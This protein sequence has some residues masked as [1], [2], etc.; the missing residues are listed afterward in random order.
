MRF[1]LSTLLLSVV[2]AA[3]CLGWYIDH[4]RSRG[5]NI[6]GAWISATDR[7]PMIM[8]DYSTLDVEQNGTFS[9]VQYSQDSWTTFSGTYCANEDGTFTFHVTKSVTKDSLI[10]D[11]PETTECDL[12]F[13]CRCAID[14]AG[15][16]MIEDC[17]KYIGFGL[18]PLVTWETLRP[19]TF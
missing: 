8:S 15:Y 16:L 13:N 11:S 5:T 7:K 2:I 6:C 19:S 10:D 18:G 17:K 12:R 3:I 4:T 14:S 9:K 1:R